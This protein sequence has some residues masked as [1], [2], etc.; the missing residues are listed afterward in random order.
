MAYNRKNDLNGMRCRV[1][2]EKER[3]DLIRL[4]VTPSSSQILVE[5]EDG[6]KE[7]LFP[8]EVTP[9]WGVNNE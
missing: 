5:N 1:I 6:S 2:V 4:G 9:M 3:D 8:W 7:L